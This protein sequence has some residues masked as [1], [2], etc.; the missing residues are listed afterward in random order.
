MAPERERR[1]GRREDSSSAGAAILR[2]TN[3][4]A[5]RSATSQSI[6]GLQGSVPGKKGLRVAG[7]TVVTVMVV[8]A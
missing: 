7:A 6:P 2:A 5:P 3:A 8:D 4:N 1:A